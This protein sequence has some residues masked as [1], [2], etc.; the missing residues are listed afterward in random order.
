MAKAQEFENR[1]LQPG[2]PTL[3]IVFR[4][5]FD[6]EFHVEHSQHQEQGDI[7]AL[8]CLW[9]GAMRAVN[10]VAYHGGHSTHFLI[11]VLE[12]EQHGSQFLF[13]EVALI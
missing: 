9:R 7:L 12:A 3:H 13:R 1:R 10:P 6:L 8:S 11:A 5:T 2:G 4:A